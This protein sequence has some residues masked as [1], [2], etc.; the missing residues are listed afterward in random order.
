[1]TKPVRVPR[2]A[3]LF[4][5][6]G[7]VRSLPVTG[8]AA[9]VKGLYGRIHDPD[10]SPVRLLLC[11]LS[12]DSATTIDWPMPV[13][14]VGVEEMYERP[15]ALA[16]RVRAAGADVVV[17]SSTELLVRHGRAVA[18]AAGAALVYEMHDDEGLVQA[19][20]GADQQA[21]TEARELQQAA[22]T[23][24]DAVVAFTGRDALAAGHLGA[25]EVHVVPCGVD[26]G[27]R[28]D[29][30]ERPRAVGFVGNLYYEP[31]R[32]AAVWLH[33]VLAP[34]LRDA[35][36]RIDVF[37]RYPARLTRELGPTPVRYRGP[38][39]DLR[40]ALCST[41]IGVAPLDSGSG[42][43]LKILEYMAAGLAVV[44]TPEAV[45]GLP[46]APDW[47]LICRPGMADLPDLV[48]SLLADDAR[49][50][51]LAD[52]A[53]D[54]AAAYAWTLIAKG[55]RRVFAHVTRSATVAPTLT[56]YVAR[57]AARPPYWLAEWR[58]QYGRREAAQST[59]YGARQEESPV[60]DYAASSATGGRG[61]VAGLAPAIDCARI[62][63]ATATGHTFPAS[64]ALVG[65]GERGVLF[66]APAGPG[67]P[68]PV[69]KVYGH[70]GAE[71]R[72][73]ELSGLRLAGQ[74][75]GVRVPQVLASAAAP[76][77][78]AWLA[79]TRLDG[80][81]ADQFAGLDER[82]VA[83]LVARVAA[84]LHTIPDWEL[85]RLEPHVLNLRE[86][87]AADPGI[88]ALRVEL[89]AA[90]TPLD[91]VQEQRCVI[92]FVHGDLGA[93]R[94]ENVLVAAT[95]DA[96]GIIDFERSGRG[97][98]YEDLSRMYAG[99][100]YGRLGSLLV[101]TYTAERAALGQPLDLDLDHLMWHLARHLRWVLQWS[102][103]IDTELTD[104]VRGLARDVIEQ[105]AAAAS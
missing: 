67:G 98:I 55:A 59:G 88:E 52:G 82:G 35:G 34:E 94:G 1:M 93:G 42:Q 45:V 101:K 4:D 68:G 53:R 13:E 32:R 44:A 39:P 84:R 77:A 100:A 31:N 11:D 102:P 69:L 104:S 15:T 30:A 91:D 24:A 6:A 29:T 2:I 86:T 19:S 56:P 36:A 72:H 71:R 65:Y 37:G 78:Q 28:P 75:P 46:D 18:E 64:S 26:L 47:A 50:R 9:R 70:R 33:R 22:V 87:P 62:A 8:A 7:F 74:Q 12:P 97:C 54:A 40:T 73:R 25:R 76:G 103:A 14:Y 99:A 85:T 80:R 66:V 21:V 58:S 83:E 89:C 27:P 51:A 95:D 105:V 79:M 16:D 38:V 48:R 49:R 20:I 90:Y 92:G 60:E 23:R 96:P 57:L 81:P 17:M 63:A 61:I 10:R 3:V 5:T 41:S 43:K